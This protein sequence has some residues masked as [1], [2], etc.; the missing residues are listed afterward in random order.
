[1]AGFVKG[2][3]KGEAGCAGFGGVRLKVRTCCGGRRSEKGYY[4]S[5][6][7]LGG[8]VPAHVR[9]RRD[10]CRSFAARRPEP[11]AAGA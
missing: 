11:G 6:S 5:C 8:E 3:W 9:C 4:V 10:L 1:M 2:V 7:V